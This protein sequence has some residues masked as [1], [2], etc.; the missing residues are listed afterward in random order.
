VEEYV[1]PGYGG[2]G[3]EDRPLNL[4]NQTVDAYTMLLA[5]NR[6]Q[7]RIKTDYQ[8]LEGFAKHFELAV[9]NLIK[10]IGLEF[11]I[12]QWVMDA[13][14]S[15][16]VVK[17]HIADSGLVEIEPDRWMD[18]GSPFVSNVSL[19]DFC[20]DMAA[21]KWSEVRW[22]G[23]MYRIPFED[24]KEGIKSGM[25]NEHAK[26]ASPTSKY[27]GGDE[28]R[29]EDISRGHEV[30]FDELEPMIDLA[31]IWIPRD[32]KIYTFLVAN[33]STFDLKTTPPIAEMD[34][35]GPEHGPYH[36]LG[37]NDVPNN[38]MPVAP[39]LHLDCLSRTINS[40]LRKQIKQA[41]RQRDINIYDASAQETA[42]NLQQSRDGD[43]RGV[44]NI[45]SVGVHKIGGPDPANQAFTASAIDMFDRAAGNLPA[46]LGLGQSADTLGQEQLIHGANSR[47]EG[48]MQY[49]VVD[50][51]SRVIRATSYLL[52]MDEVKEITSQYT[53][54]DT[55]I[56]VT[57][58]W[59]PGDRDGNF[60]DYNFEISPF[61][62][63]Y[64]APGKDV[65]AV[66][67]LLGTVY[68][69][70]LQMIQQQGG[71][72]DFQELNEFYAQNLNNPFLRKLLMFSEP[73]EDDKGPPATD[74][75][76]PPTSNRTYTRISKSAGGTESGKNHARQ[77]A[78]LGAANTQQA[79]STQL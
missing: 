33:R 20:F 72:L 37:F 25:Y 16:G 9:N 23:D 11:T 2:K 42:Q 70:M 50:A 36:I 34:W 56:R 53:V 57:S 58:K 19:D 4:I 76:K 67:T 62:M 28:K 18:P 69:P 31:D 61:S 73:L 13:F 35:E 54:Q 15:I 24:V 26:Q 39:A 14:F 71:T 6:P 5:A 40:L 12:R 79:E 78:L 44:D 46:L 68:A 45:E 29:Q 47:K 51:V 30:D 74:L 22:A 60:M 52:W 1:G 66:N 55:S 77:M 32:G 41:E 7:V 43:W 27:S 48:Q 17:V 38:I 8:E 65:E 75:K 10:E 3:G 59:K 49:R 21:K 64:Q 63:T